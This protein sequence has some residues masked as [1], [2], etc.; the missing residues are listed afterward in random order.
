[1]K[2][3]NTIVSLQDKTL[4]G[5]WKSS[6]LF[7]F[8]FF[9][10][11]AFFYVTYKLYN[12][13]LNYNVIITY[14]LIGAFVSVVMNFITGNLFTARRRMYKRKGFSKQRSHA[15]AYANSRHAHMMTAIL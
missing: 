7:V 15:Q 6:I 12:K 11:F 10:M 9:A 14:C 1:M 8:V 3:F 2:V 13:P 4:T 5:S